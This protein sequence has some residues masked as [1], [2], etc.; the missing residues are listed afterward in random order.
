[1]FDDPTQKRRLEGL[2]HPRVAA[3]R[4]RMEAA[5]AAD[6]A[7]KAIVQDVP[8]LLE[9]GLDE[10]CDVLVFVD[11]ERAVRERRVQQHRGWSAAELKRREKNQASLDSKRGRADYVVINNASEGECFD[12]VRR[13]FSKI[14]AS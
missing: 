8:L 6:P 7:V 10:R 14:L 9:V 3:E 13:V 12:Q 5:F 11:A 4:E 2:I 1:V